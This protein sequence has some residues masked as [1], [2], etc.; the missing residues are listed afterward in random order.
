MKPLKDKRDREETLRESE[1]A[2]G[3]QK[4]TETHKNTYAFRL[5]HCAWDHGKDTSLMKETEIKRETGSKTARHTYGEG[6][7]DKVQERAEEREGKTDKYQAHLVEA[8][9]KSP[10]SSKT[11]MKRTAS[12]RSASHRSKSVAEKTL[13]ACAYLYHVGL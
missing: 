5:D 2:S 4:E 13:I 7:T 11:V 6:C 12:L 3:R 9:R 10:R 1:Q 8:T